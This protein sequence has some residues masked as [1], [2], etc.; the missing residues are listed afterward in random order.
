VS[1][2]LLLQSTQVTSG[3]IHGAIADCGLWC[4]RKNAKGQVKGHQSVQLYYYLRAKDT[5]GSG[6]Y[7]VSLDT[8]SR[9][10]QISIYALRRWIKSGLDLKLFHAAIRYKVGV[11]RV[12][13]SCVV[14]VCIQNGIAD[15]GAIAKI[16]MSALG[17]L[18][19]IATHAQALLLQHQ[20]RYREAK[21][22]KKC[23]RARKTFDPSEVISSSLCTGPI[24][25]RRG[26]LIFLRRSHLP[27]GGSQR[28]IAWELGRHESTIQ[29]RLS[30]SYRRRHGIDPIPKVQLLAAAKV[31]ETFLPA[32]LTP[33]RRILPGQSIV[34]VPGLGKFRRCTNLYSENLELISARRLRSRLKVR[35]QPSVWDNQPENDPVYQ[36]FRCQFKS[37]ID[38][39][40]LSKKITPP[41]ELSHKC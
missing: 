37:V 34:E 6:W 18:K 20:S 10:L 29:R 16:D 13:Y 25:F 17:E 9:D 26:R 28:R 14:N 27:Y 23:D 4:D 35:S 22:S 40:S 38:K 3:I 5:K 7:D 2:N 12:W 11:V 30:D 1:T 36:V 41:P 8:V 33:I 15:I 21:K 39:G 24:L 31:V 19:Y 32:R